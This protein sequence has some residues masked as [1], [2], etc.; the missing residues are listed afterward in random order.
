LKT[1]QMP[2]VL[3]DTPYRLGKLLSEVRT[4]FGTKQQ[5]T[6][7]CDLT[8]TNEAVF[9]GSVASVQKQ[10]GNRKAEFILILHGRKG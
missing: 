2:I 7:A 10:A 5:L 9:R 6:L 1:F 3:M 4:V 8:L